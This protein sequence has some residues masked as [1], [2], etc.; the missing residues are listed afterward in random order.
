LAFVVNRKAP[1]G[2]SSPWQLRQCFSRIGFTC[3]EKST[4]SAAAAENAT[5]AAANT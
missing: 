1:F 4:F 5:D 3:F 2:F